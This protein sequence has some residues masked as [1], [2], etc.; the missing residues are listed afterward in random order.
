MFLLAA[1]NLFLIGEKIISSKKNYDLKIII[2][3]GNKFVD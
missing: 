1:D 2:L 3:V